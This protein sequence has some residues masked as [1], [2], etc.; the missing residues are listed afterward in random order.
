MRKL[1]R[2]L[3]PRTIGAQLIVGVALVHLLL[4]TIFVLDTVHRQR[5]FLLERSRERVLF[6]AAALAASSLRSMIM[7]DLEG[8]AETVAAF[9]REPGVRYAMVTDKTGRVLAHTD[10][11]K[12]GLYI[13]DAASVQALQGLAQKRLLALGGN[14]VSAMAPVSVGARHLG[15]A[16]IA[17]DRNA[18]E[19]HVDRVTK[20]GLLYMGWAVLVG[21]VF[22]IS[23]AGT[24]TRPLRLLLRGARRLSRDQL[25]TLV[26]VTTRNEVGIVTRAFNEAM[27]KLARQRAELQRSRDQLEQRVQ[28]RTREL[29]MSNVAL[30]REI[31]ERVQAQ[32]ALR[33]AH[34]ELEER[35][36]ERTAELAQTNQALAREISERVR[37]EEALQGANAALQRSNEDLKQFAY[38][39]SHDLQEPL[40]M[41][42]NFTGLLQKRYSER[43][44]EPGR[45]FMQYA[46]EGATRMQAMIRDLLA[47]SRT[48]NV[49]EHQ[50]TRVDC[51]EA[52][53]KALLNL[54][55]AI[56]ENRAHIDAGPLPVVRA[57]EVAMVQLLQNLVGNAIKYRSEEP[58]HIRIFCSK[59]AG[60]W[61]FGVQDNGI[62]IAAEYQARIFGL[63]KRLHTNK[64]PGTG[65]GLAICSRIVQR[66][67]G[68]MWVESQDGRGSTF[69]FTLPPER[70][71]AEPRAEPGPLIAASRVSEGGNAA[72]L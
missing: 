32:D 48:M 10:R 30:A 52:L 20:S 27:E 65:I 68:R 39:V 59:V 34:N 71:M 16:W 61:R 55:T 64:Y 60:E 12:S 14:V 23:L 18:D 66:Y 63:F 1:L 26:P 37:A 19:A 4:M 24:I 15:W 9:S 51:N 53:D 6:Q 42:S 56:E 45:E 21:T 43:L 29:A 67:G 47:Y 13:T 31:T 17:W 36:R 25:D 54:E 49:D 70:V 41:V 7:N 22:A 58:P 44:D 3:R 8:L 33:R 5:S 38:A 62:G 57:A 40:R 28:E 35:V 50:I 46:I 72:G 69:F 2:L 11:T